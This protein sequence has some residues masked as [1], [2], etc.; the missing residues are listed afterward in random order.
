MTDPV[1]MRTDALIAHIQDHYHAAHRRELPALIALAEKVERVHGDRNEAPHG[2]STWLKRVELDLETHM[3]KEE[4][5]LFPAM[6]RGL[7][8]GIR[9]PIAMMRYE[10]EQHGTSIAALQSLT[11]DFS[12]PADACGSWRRL[13]SGLGKLCGDLAEHMSL[14][15][16]ELFRRFELSQSS[17]CICAHRNA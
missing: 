10:H 5:V 12:P 16:N 8:D 7:A 6:L 13:Y 2:L 3:Q 1:A 15:N 14:E 9:Q 17:S 4:H 11:N